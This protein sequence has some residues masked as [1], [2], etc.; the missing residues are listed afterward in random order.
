MKIQDSENR[1]LQCILNYLWYWRQKDPLESVVE[2]F[3]S[4]PATYVYTIKMTGEWFRSHKRDRK[5]DFQDYIEKKL[6]EQF[7]E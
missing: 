4:K 2:T 3:F 5:K 6:F 1:E 7:N